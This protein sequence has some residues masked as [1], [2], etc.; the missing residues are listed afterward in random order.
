MPVAKISLKLW[1][2][3]FYLGIRKFGLS[4]LKQT[5]QRKQRKVAGHMSILVFLAEFFIKDI[6][7][8]AIEAAKRCSAK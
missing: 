3:L 2:Y 5:K 7:E 6:P 8:A 1:N 4:N